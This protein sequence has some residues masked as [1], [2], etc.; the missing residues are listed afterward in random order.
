MAKRFRLTPQGHVH[1]LDLIAWKA[2]K[3]LI[4]AGT[5]HDDGPLGTLQL[6]LGPNFTSKVCVRTNDQGELILE[7]D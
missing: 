2:S 1:D 6:G 3:P 7:F 5:A 4:A